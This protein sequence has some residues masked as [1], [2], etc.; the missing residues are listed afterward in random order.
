MGVGRGA[1]RFGFGN[2]S[3]V[4]PVTGDARELGGIV[5]EG[6]RVRGIRGNSVP[7]LAGY[8]RQLQRCGER[9]GV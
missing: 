2:R 9:A 4:H 6:E 7:D 8:I 3:A 5:M 1:G